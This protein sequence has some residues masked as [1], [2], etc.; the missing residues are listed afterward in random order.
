[1]SRKSS[2]ERKPPSGRT[3][4]CIDDQ[5]DYLEA[6]RLV[7]EREGHRVL[8]AQGGAAGLAILETERVDI[9]LLDYIMPGLSAEE[10]IAQIR[11]PTVQVVL[12]TGY[13][14]ER[15]PREL[16]DHLNIQGYCDK[17]RGSEE[18]L[19]WV[20]VALRFSN[21]VRQLHSS[22]E[23]LRQVL[24]HR[25]R[26]E[27]RLPLEIELDHYLDETLDTLELR[28]GFVGIATPDLAW[29]PP[30]RLE[31]SP[32]WSD[33]EVSD[34]RLVAARGPWSV[35]TALSSQVE[36]TFLRALLEAP[37]DETSALAN[38]AGVV[39]LRADGRWVGT[40]Y[41]DPLPPHGTPRWDLLHFHA[42]EMANR[43]HN[44]SMA[45]LD[46]VTS[47][48]NKAFWRQAAW[49]DLRAAFRFGHPASLALV[50]VAE[51]DRIRQETPRAADQVLEGV[52]RAIRHS[53]RGTDLAGRCDKDEIA[54]LLPHTDN[55]GAARFAEMLADRL[56]QLVVQ[57]ADGPVTPQGSIGVATF[58]LHK[59]PMDQLPHPMPS[60]FYPAAELLLRAR[61]AEALPLVAPGSS[62]FAVASHDSVDWPDPTGMAN[63][64]VRSTLWA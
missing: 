26:G 5:E 16:L 11:D 30:P 54:L 14:T 12:L 59:L 9:V 13:S 24:G 15:P 2:H 3:I 31:E 18:L 53:I 7:L 46:P 41:V 4:L 20:E 8:T 51:L 50:S 63:H 22:R 55:I 61:A 23:G 60:D 32:S 38:G 39:P 35:G 49:R 58:D 48:Q 47:L 36:E 1:M 34:L 17:T 25:L 57:T 52:G 43:V 33:D 6:S 28:E 19:L 56:D 44:R 21:T 64:L 29:V 27:E 37:F 10:I 62:G 45:T 42:S 40:L